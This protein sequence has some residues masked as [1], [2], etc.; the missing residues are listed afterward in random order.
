MLKYVSDPAQLSPLGD[1]ASSIVS[2]I[3]IA[4]TAVTHSGRYRC[5][6][7]DAPHDEVMVHVIDGTVRWIC[8]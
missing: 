5:E 2:R 6:P 8:I 4:E 7:G 3:L 1:G